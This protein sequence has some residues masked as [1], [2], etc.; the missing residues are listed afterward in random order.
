MLDPAGA[1]PRLLLVTRNFPPL[2]GGME[3]LNQR[4]AREL[5]ID[6]IVDVCGPA[7]TGAHAS[8]AEHVSE[9][10]IA[11]L[12]RFFRQALRN[13]WRAAARRPEWVLAGSGL[14]APLAWLAA[15]RARAASAV[16]LHGLDIIVPS[17][18]YQAAWL[19]FIRRMDRVLVNSR[20]TAELAVKRGVSRER[21]HVLHPG[22]DPGPTSVS[23]PGRF[24]RAHGLG[25]V[26]LLLSVGRL[27]RRK[28]LAEFVANA[29][30][31]VVGR[32]PD[33]ILAVIGG[34]AKDALHGVVGG[35]RER[36]TAAARAAGVE[37]NL[38][39][40]PPCDDL[41]LSEAYLAADC[42]VFP[43]LDVPGDVE[44][45]GMVALEAAAHG[46][47][48]VAFRV[49]GVADAVGEGVS[50]TLVTAN[51]YAAMAGAVSRVLGRDSETRH[52]DGLEGR[53]FAA[54]FE[55]PRFGQRIRALLPAHGSAAGLASQAS[56]GMG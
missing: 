25:S 11:P 21:I 36:I 41:E 20:N 14:M 12:G 7:G 39:L 3:K 2:Q 56:G 37:S 8:F 43:V 4:M 6:R 10:D 42:H 26:P 13:A 55:W 40:L 54:R 9:A 45:F 33:A 46:L 53:A 30:P 22:A 48:T 28:G 49:G 29:F 17:R 15:K 52:R 50:G 5:A 19:P 31:V 24:R 27:T 18:I 34:E 44:G 47:S 38:R 32:Y 51:D 23:D 16:Y 1:R 35:E